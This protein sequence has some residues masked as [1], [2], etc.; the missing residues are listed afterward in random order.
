[1]K[2]IVYDTYG[3]PDVLNI[4]EAPVPVPKENEVLIKVHAASVNYGDLLAR[5]IR[6][7]DPRDFHMPSLFLLLAKLHF[8]LRKP[9]Q[10]IL[11]SEFSGEIEAAGHAVTKYRKGDRVFGY[12][13]QQMGAYA[14]YFCMPDNGVMA[15]RPDNIGPEEAASIPMGAIM[16]LYLLREKGNL[17]PGKKVL[18]IGASGSI[19]SAAVQ[20]L[21]HYFE[22]EVTGV[23]GTPRVS[24]VKSLGADRVIDYTREDYSKQ[25]ETYDLIFD[26]L[27]KSSFA[28]CRKIL[29][30]NG[31]YLP[32]SFK[33]KQL[34]QMIG[35][36]ISGGPS[37][38]KVVCAIAPGSVSDLL[39]VRELIEAGKFKS[40]VDK[41]FSP[42]QAAE[43]HRYVEE[44]HK[45]AQ[46]VIRFA[47]E[48][49]QR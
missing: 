31:R 8:G 1:M 43:A 17:K 12:L 11:G 37:G 24:Y 19:G 38:K 13:G 28:Q 42:D 21:K 5:K 23:C 49:T 7:A 46:V 33:M 18:V 32:A 25:D 30:P 10:K 40:I 27:G 14:E 6:D 34:M 4:Q 26:V 39:T 44:G 41:V 47:P 2:A 15:L 16:A 9:K 29:K 20:L 35:T 36:S 45:K 48:K 22:A 3:P